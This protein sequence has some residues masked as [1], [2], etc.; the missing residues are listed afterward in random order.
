METSSPLMYLAYVM[1]AMFFLIIAYVIVNYRESS[2]ALKLYADHIRSTM[3]LE[4]V[5]NFIRSYRKPKI[6][7]GEDRSG[8]YVLVR[9]YVKEFNK[10]K[11][12][13]LVHVDKI[14]KK[15]VK[16]EVQ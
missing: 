2:R 4:E 3:E 6:E 14:T 7:V 11:P 5:Q 10:E 8:K 12:S 1:F 16:T 13:V 9:W 15:P